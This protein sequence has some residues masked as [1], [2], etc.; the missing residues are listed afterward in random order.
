M[1]NGTSRKKPTLTAR[2][3]GMCARECSLCFRHRHGNGLVSRATLDDVAFI[4]P[5]V[6]GTAGL[7]ALWGR[8]FRLRSIE[9]RAS[10]LPSCIVIPL[11]KRWISFVQDRLRFVRKSGGVLPSGLSL[12]QGM[13]NGIF[14]TL[15]CAQY[16]RAA[17]AALPARRQLVVGS[18]ARP[19]IGRSGPRESWRRRSCSSTSSRPSSP[20]ETPAEGPGEEA[21]EMR[22][23]SF[24]SSVCVVCAI[25][26]DLRRA[27]HVVG[28]S[29]TRRC[30]CTE[31]SETR[32]LDRRVATLEPWR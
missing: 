16:L 21:K 12:S 19:S 6:F 27:S 1:P 3:L 7:F 29:S 8:W 20:R 15:R 22:S 2:P 14:S 30:R 25:F 28:A 5:A 18:V 13:L 11:L 31:G 26:R 9:A 10:T 23:N 17:A 32:P 24:P 4:S